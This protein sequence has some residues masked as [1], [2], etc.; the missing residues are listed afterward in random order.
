MHEDDTTMQKAA[1]SSSQLQ[2]LENQRLCAVSRSRGSECVTRPSMAG[3]L[4]YFGCLSDCYQRDPDNE[5]FEAVCVMV[6]Y[7]IENGCALFF[8][9]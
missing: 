5:L 8:V 4:K 7:Q 1:L 2:T 9:V 3:G 6:N